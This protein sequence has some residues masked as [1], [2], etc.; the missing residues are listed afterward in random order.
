MNRPTTV[1]WKAVKRVS[2]YLKGSIGQWLQIS[3]SCLIL[4]TAFSVADWADDPDDRPSRSGVGLFFGSTLLSW[5]SKKQPIVSRSNTES[6]CMALDFAAAKL[7][8]IQHLL[9]DLGISLSKPPPLY[10]DNRSAIA[11][12]ANPVFRAHINTLTLTTT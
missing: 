6:Q 1:H 4:Y 9:T 3:P 7:S 11:L 2:R 10:C 12:A 8:W 5:F